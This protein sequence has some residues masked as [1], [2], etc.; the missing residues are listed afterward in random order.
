MATTSC[1]GL[2][3]GDNIVWGTSGDGDNIVWGTAAD[4]DNIVWG[5]DCGGADCDNIVWGTAA[6]GDNIVWGTAADGDNIVWGTADDGDNIV[7]GTA[8]DGDNIVWGTAADG[9]NIVWGTFGDWDHIVWGAP[10]VIRASGMGGRSR[11]HQDHPTP[12]ECVPAGVPQSEGRRVVGQPGE[13]SAITF[14]SSDGRPVPKPWR[15]RRGCA[16]Q[17]NRIDTSGC[18]KDGADDG[19]DVAASGCRPANG[20]QRLA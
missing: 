19:V 11:P 20:L 1:G 10:T 7:W 15:G 12:V 17:R 9:D 6:D 14:I 16:H 5:T 18:A 8:A 13:A 3:D 4:G 2:R